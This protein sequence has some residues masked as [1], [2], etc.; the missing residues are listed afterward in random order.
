LPIVASS[1]SP[2]HPL[3]LLG[4]LAIDAALDI[5]QRVDALDRFER[6]GRDRGRF[7][8]APGISRDVCQLEE[9]PSRMGPTECGGDRPLRARRVV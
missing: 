7:L 3:T 9:L 5:E 2:A 1:R 4:A 6:D 8:A